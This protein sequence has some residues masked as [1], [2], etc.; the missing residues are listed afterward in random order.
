[1]QSSATSELSLYCC[2]SCDDW[3]TRRPGW[4]K[5]PAHCACVLSAACRCPLQELCCRCM[6]A[7]C[8]KRGMG[9]M[10]NSTAQTTQVC[11]SHLEPPGHHPELS[12]DQISGRPSRWHGCWRVGRACA[13]G[14]VT[15][16]CGCHGR[17]RQDQPCRHPA[18]WCPPYLAS[19]YVVFVLQ[20][21]VAQ[22]LIRESWAD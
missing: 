13:V 20:L 17:A 16:S 7:H 3:D 14:T 19:P 22:V 10:M 12:G 11:P 9:C 15:Q 5:N 18:L 21:Y 8:N 6:T 4:P 1:M 2:G